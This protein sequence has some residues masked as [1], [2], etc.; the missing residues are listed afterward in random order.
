M[1]RSEMEICKV[2]LQYVLLTLDAIHTAS[3]VH[4]KHPITEHI[5]GACLSSSESSEPGE[6]F[7]HLLALAAFFT[8]DTHFHLT[9][10]RK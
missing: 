8:H 2:L 5:I 1:K 7:Y 6:G 3:R 10:E 4:I 9:L